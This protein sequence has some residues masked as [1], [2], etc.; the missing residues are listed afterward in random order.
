MQSNCK[1]I[2]LVVGIFFCFSNCKNYNA[3]ATVIG[4]LSWSYVFKYFCYFTYKNC[5]AEAIM[6]VT[7]VPAVKAFL[8]N[9]LLAVFV[10]FISNASVAIANMSD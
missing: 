5:N 8:S 9:I 6:Q 1:Y 7:R 3:K 4:V 10:F 2:R